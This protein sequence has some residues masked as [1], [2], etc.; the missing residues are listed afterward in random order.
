MTSFPATRGIIS[1]CFAYTQHPKQSLLQLNYVCMCVCFLFYLGFPCKNSSLSLRCHKRVE[2]QIS[3]SLLL[4]LLC[5][6]SKNRANIQTHSLTHSYTHT[7]RTHQDPP[8]SKTEPQEANRQTF[9]ATQITTTMASPCLLSC[10][11]SPDL[12]TLLFSRCSL[13][14]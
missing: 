13:F 5:Q 2:F 9:K 6:I 4:L 1:W 11:P 14:L 3:L 10:R 12:W 8:T 7:Q